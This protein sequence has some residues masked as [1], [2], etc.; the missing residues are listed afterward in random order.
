MCSQM[1]GSSSFYRQKLITPGLGE[2]PQN[3]ADPSFS[4]YFIHTFIDK[5]YVKDL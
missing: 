5:A 4:H 2:T 1:V 3:G